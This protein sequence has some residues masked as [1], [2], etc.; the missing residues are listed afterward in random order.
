MKVNSVN[1]NTTNLIREKKTVF[2]SVRNNKPDTFERTTTSEKTQN[3]TNPV[4]VREEFSNTIN[5]LSSMHDKAKTAFENQL[6]EDGWSARLA[7]KLSGLWG[8]KNRASLV[9]KDLIKYDNQIKALDAAAKKGNFKA[10][11]RETFGVGYN[12]KEIE[13]FEK[14][15]KQYTLVNISREIASKTEEK[16]RPYISYF[17]KNTQYLTPENHNTESQKKFAEANTKLGEF[18]AN[19]SEMLGGKEKFNSFLKKEHYNELSGE[20][21]AKVATQIAEQIIDGANS[22]LKEIRNGK[23]DMQLQK[24]YDDAFKKAFGSKND[25]VK[26]VDKYVRS[27]QIGAVFIRDSILAGAIG[28]TIA[29]SGT[30][31]PALVGSGVTFVGCAGLDM[32]EYLTNNVDNKEDMS[33]D[34]VK[35][36][37]KDAAI[38]GVEY[39]VGSK[40]YDF[41][42]V[43]KTASPLLNGTLNT[44]RIMGIELPTA[45]VAE[46]ARTGKWATE[47]M[48]PKSFIKLVFTAYAIE[49]YATTAL[50]ARH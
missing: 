9:K 12:K 21:K 35:D 30:A 5:T 17:E 39:I 10:K 2:Y 23:N 29:T 7:D 25:I 28:A 42:P 14:I 18:E 3:Q 31:Y 24:E 27:Q 26:R 45:F 1:L 50:T 43:A 47:D 33:K 34:V 36:I 11:F 37:I 46:Y 13:N 44:A 49:E 6:A 22:S 4:N 15:S 40:L 19:L 48:D 20:D 38:S 16:F 8:S 32:S 41:I